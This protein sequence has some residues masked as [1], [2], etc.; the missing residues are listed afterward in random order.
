MVPEAR[1]TDDTQMALAA[2]VE[3]C[4]YAVRLR[5]VTA[6]LSDR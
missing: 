6:G 2:W 1:V 3:R 5:A 4:E